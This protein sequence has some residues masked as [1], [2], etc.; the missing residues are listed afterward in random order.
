MN[1]IIFREV[2]RFRN[3][4]FMYIVVFFFLFILFIFGYGIVTQ[5]VFHKQFGNNPMSDFGLI[6]TGSFSV[7]ISTTLFLLFFLGNLEIIITPNG[8]FYKYFPF[9]NKL[10]K[11]DK[12]SIKNYQVRQ[13][14]PIREFGGCGLRYNYKT[15]TSCYNIRGTMGLEIE[16]VNGRR[17]MLGTQE[18]HEIKKSMDELFRIH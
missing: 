16:L 17:I 4:I 10:R 7:V 2:Q 13:Y 9:I 1:E 5:L 8:L 18:P 6:L 14:K 3:T 12:S 11:I 15:K